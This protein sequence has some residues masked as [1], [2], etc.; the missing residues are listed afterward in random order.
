M[1][2]TL[3]ERVTALFW[4]SVTNFILPGESSLTEAICCTDSEYDVMQSRYA[5]CR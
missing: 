4:F 3:A 5:S 2:D 1:L